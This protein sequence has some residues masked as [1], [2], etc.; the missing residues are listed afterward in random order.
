MADPDL[1]LRL[2]LVGALAGAL[3]AECVSAPAPMDAP[4][5]RPL[6]VRAPAVAAARRP[7]GQD[8][9]AAEVA[10]MLARPLFRA[11]RR[12]PRRPDG[13]PVAGLHE[14]GLPRLSGIMVSA[15]E[16]QAIFEGGAKPLVA[17]VGDR[18]GD[19]TIAAIATG[20]VTLDGPRGT[21]TIAPS[22]DRDRIPPPP[23]PVVATDAER[24]LNA[25]TANRPIP[26]AQTLR[27]LM[28]QRRA[29]HAP[30]PGSPQG[31]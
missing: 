12:P 1:L 19:Y 7:A 13:A 22:F 17:R 30:Q 5:G 29:M 8:P 31:P 24:L 3:G 20:S 15:D 11:D 23:P 25:A 9:I 28:N 4:A 16:A 21:Q 18:V 26:P 27:G 14:A 10:A 6:A 2:A